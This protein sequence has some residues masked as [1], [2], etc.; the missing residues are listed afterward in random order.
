MKRQAL[1]RFGLALWLGIAWQLPT[2]AVEVSTPDAT[3]GLKATLLKG[4]EVAISS[5]GRP[6]GFMG[7]ERVRIP[8]PENLRR[9]ESLAR[10]LGMGAQT[11]ELLAAMNHAAEAAVVEAK[12]LLVNAVK[13]MSFSDARGIL[14]GGEDAATQYFRRTTAASM[15]EKFRPIV[16]RMTS[17][18]ELAGKYNQYVGKVAQLGLIDKSDA[19]LD[20]YVTGKAM[21][22]VFLMIAD[23]EKAIRHDPIGTGSALLKRVFANSAN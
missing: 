13:N 7:N 18:T 17:K 3:A 19:D 6:D 15:S 4:S 2:L 9:G 23:Q 14:G 8:L 10:K 1:I 5:L 11:D 22:A 21:D 16:K 20:G 12:P